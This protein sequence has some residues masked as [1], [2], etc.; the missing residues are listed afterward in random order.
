MSIYADIGKRNAELIDGRD[1]CDYTQE[2]I[3][4]LSEKDKEKL[5]A[6]QDIADALF[7]EKS[8]RNVSDED[9]ERAFGVMFQKVCPFG[10]FTPCNS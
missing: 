7:R 4:Q 3:S 8:S 9:L 1:D 6:E 5:F 10:L 2:L